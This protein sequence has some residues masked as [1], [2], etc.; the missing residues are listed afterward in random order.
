MTATEHLIEAERL[1]TE[2]KKGYQR[3]AEQ[4]VPLTFDNV[5]WTSSVVYMAEVHVQIARELRG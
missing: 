5:A 2:V 1:L 4:R 3:Y